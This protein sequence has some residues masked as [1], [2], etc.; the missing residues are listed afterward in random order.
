MDKRKII[1]F[2]DS[3][4]RVE[5]LFDEKWQENLEKQQKAQFWLSLGSVFV[6][7]CILGTL[8]YIMNYGL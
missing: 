1:P 2:P 8:L 5:R 4:K 3:H 7:F 6:G